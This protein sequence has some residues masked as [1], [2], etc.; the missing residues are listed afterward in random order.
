MVDSSRGWVSLTVN[1]LY[2]VYLCIQ[3]KPYTVITFVY[4]DAVKNPF[5]PGA[6]TPP[7]ELAGRD[8]L[9]HRMQIALER[10]C[11][12]MPQRSVILVGLRGV[13]KTVLLNRIREIASEKG[14]Q[15]LH[16]EAHEEKSLPALLIP[17]LRKILL[18]LDAGKQLSERAKYG[19]RVLKSFAG[20]FKAK[21][22]WNEQ[23]DLELG[24]EPQIGTADSGDL[25]HDLSELLVAVAEAA[26]D[27]QTAICL[28]IDEIQYLKE[29]ELS[30]LIMGLHQ[31]SQR[32]L[33][34]VL[35]GAGLPL[36]LGLA[37]RSKSY[38]ERLFEFPSV[39]KLEEPAAKTAL[40]R[41]VA[42]QNVSFTTKAIAIILEKTQGYPYFL[43]QWGYEA[44]NTA[45]QTPINEE[46]IHKATEKALRQLD[47]S[48]FRVRFDRLTKREKDF[49]FAMMSVGGDHQ[50]SGDIAERMGVKVTSIGPLRSSL[51]KKGMIYSPAHGDNAF[52][53]PLFD[54]FLRRQQRK[55]N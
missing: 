50:R 9:L 2:I 10:L 8:I 13:G 17:P 55:Q 44:W 48:F 19:L 36:I 32:Q 37:G 31:V 51:I 14:F 34:L 30:A 40:E 39:G 16:I 33:S 35:V 43:Q 47:E 26:K 12:G 15:A 49:L 38:A 20:S 1:Q 28:L 52:T 11:L 6:G 5:A 42:V 41:P 22:N 53:V 3:I 18:S 7:P 54:G 46:D 29:K 27:R 25:E 21:I 45:E 23:V 24:I 4:M